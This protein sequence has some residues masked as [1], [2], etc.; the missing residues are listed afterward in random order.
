MLAMPVETIVRKMSNDDAVSRIAE[1]ASELEAFEIIVGHPLNMQGE[2]TPSTDDAIAC[3][4]AVAEALSLP[5]RLVDERLSTVS[6]Q[7]ALHRVGR[8][9]KS[10]RSVID[11]VAA[12]IILQQA[13]DTERSSGNPPGTPVEQRG[14]AT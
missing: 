4:L 10:S 13:L 1:I 6:A 2:S 9:T 12:V 11:Q 3:A 7:S 5:V 14:Q 8:T